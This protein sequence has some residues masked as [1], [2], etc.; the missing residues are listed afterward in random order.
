MCWKCDL[1]SVLGVFWSDDQGTIDR[2]GEMISA[3]MRANDVSYADAVEA[4]SAARRAEF[5]SLAADY[6]RRHGLDPA[7]VQAALLRHGM[8][9]SAVLQ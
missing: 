4:L 7:A 8:Q 6:G 5:H 2:A 9:V 1:R 3:H